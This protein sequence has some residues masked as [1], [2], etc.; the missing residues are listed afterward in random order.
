MYA[1][2]LNTLKT[3]PGG[4][5]IS[6]ARWNNGFRGSAKTFVPGNLVVIDEQI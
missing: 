6:V 5:A 3:E 1:M 4:N 2:A